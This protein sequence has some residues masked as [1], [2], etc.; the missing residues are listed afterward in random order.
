MKIGKGRVTYEARKIAIRDD[1]PVAALAGAI[2][3][4]PASTAI[5]IA[6]LNSYGYYIGEELAGTKGQDDEKMA[7]LQLAAK[8]HE[9][10]IQAS[11]AAMLL[12]Y[13]RHELAL[14]QGLPFGALFA[15]QLFKDISFLWSSEFWGTAKGTFAD[16]KHRW[17]LI[18]LLVV[19]ALLGL[20]V[21]PAS[22]TLL[23]PRMGA[24]P[25]GGTEFWINVPSDSLWSTNITA[26]G[27][28]PSCINTSTDRSCPSGDWQTLAQ[29]YLPFWQRTDKQG[30]IP[31]VIRIPGLKSIREM[32]PQTRAPSQQF[33]RP[34][35][36]ATTQYSTIADA[37]AE[38]GRLWAWVVAAAWRTKGKPWRFWSH[39]EAHFSVSAQ[40]AI[41][42]V[43]CSMKDSLASN[44]SDKVAKIYDLT[45]FAAF[46][47]KGDFPL[48]ADEVAHRGY[49]EKPAE[50]RVFLEWT[51]SIQPKN[52]HPALVAEIQVPVV[53]A[54]DYESSL[55]TVDA[56]IAPAKIQGTRNTYTVITSHLQE[57][58]LWNPAGVHGTY[59]A[60]NSWRSI[61]IDPAWA[62]FLNPKIG[63]LDSAVVHELAM[64]A[65]ILKDDEARANEKIYVIESILALMISNGLSRTNFNRGIIGELEDWDF[66]SS[67][68]TC[69]PWCSQMMPLRGPMGHGGSVYTINNHA[70]QNATKL[71]MIAEAVGYAYSPKGFTT[72]L[73]IT[74]LFLYSCIVLAHWGYMIR[75]RKSSSSWQSSAEIAALAMNSRQT[76]VLTNTGCGV[77]T[78]R[79]FKQSVR[80]VSVGGRLELAFKGLPEQESINCNT[81]YS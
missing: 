42:H 69:G 52:G 18:L 8:L 39:K 4:L 15:G 1:R 65:G 30:Y 46:Q 34:F 14:R 7:G 78:S 5:S 76:D 2:H 12:Q 51:S 36:T 63:S 40:Q 56:R 29:D 64:A 23:K 74:V 48:Y 67:T 22:A 75:T 24:W 47:N 11:I 33:S 43:R 57:S 3:L 79:I 61:V 25:A 72:I 41:V 10:T 54:S 59:G 68:P 80:V 50:P 73:S 17:R 19:C 62:A 32:Y 16:R 38:M 49:S 44:S 77:E 60:D 55:C 20:T 71:T 6:L 27:V 70:T 81:W 58:S 13:I 35:T 28:P 9:L 37:V 53:N 45:D 31:G 21:G 26:S 66:D